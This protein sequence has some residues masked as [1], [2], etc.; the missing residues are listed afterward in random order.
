MSDTAEN[1]SAIEGHADQ[2]G[3]A[4]AADPAAAGEPAAD[5]GL[6]DAELH[7]VRDELASQREDYLRLAAEMENLRKRSAREAASA[8]QFAIERFAGELLGV[9][10]SLEMGLAAAG[11]SAEALREGSEATL[12][13]LVSALEKH[14]VGVVDPEGEP[15]D[16]QQHEAMTM[17]PSESA[18]PGSVMTVV[19]KGY[20][21]NGRLLRPARVVVAAEPPAAD[22]DSA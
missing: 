7:A 1:K 4:P 19:Q 3:G 5:Q 10:D 11:A 9:V 17:Q 6:H 12:R 15:F 2:S 16:P 22:P 14:G 18:E 13:Q 20:T 21:L 8:R